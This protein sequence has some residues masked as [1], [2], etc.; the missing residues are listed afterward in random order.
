MIEKL[1]FDKNSALIIVDVQ[2]D[3]CPNGDLPVPEGERVVPLINAYVEQALESRIPIFASR[4]W[5]PVDHVSFSGQDGNWPPHCI[6]DHEGAGFHKDLAL[7]QDTVVVSKGVRLDRDQNSAFD[8]TGLAAYLR[9]KDIE[10]LFIC[11]LALDMCV[12]STVMDAINSGFATSLILEATRPVDYQD[13]IAAVEKMKQAGASVLGEY[14]APKPA[15]AS[16]KSDTDEEW[17]QPVCAKAPEWAEH[18]RFEDDD[19]PC[20]D[21]RTGKLDR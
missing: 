10:S 11:G 2:N 16:P 19:E 8:E 6:Q 5:H 4:D 18:Q 13:G 17:E 21:G 14:K 1:D 15:A 9:K 7:T 3:F 20:D 12:L